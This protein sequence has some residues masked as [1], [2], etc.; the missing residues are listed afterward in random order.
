MNTPNEHEPQNEHEHEHEQEQNHEPE[1]E[2]ENDS[3][4]MESDPPESQESGEA[5]EAMQSEEL[6]STSPQPLAHAKGPLQEYMDEN[7]LQYA[8][9][10]IRDRAIP[11]LDD[12]L[13][14]V[15]R[16]ILHSLNRNDD[17]KFIKVANIV[18]YAMQFHPHGDASIN[19]AL[20]GL[21]NKQYLIEGQGNYGNILTGHRAAASRYI[22][23]R[24]TELSRTQVFNDEITEFVP[25]YDGRG[26]EPVVLPCKIPLLLMQGAEGIAVGLSARI[27]P[28]NFQEL[29]E[30]QIAILKNKPFEVLPDFIQGGY[31]DAADYNDGNGKIKVRAKISAKD[32][33]TAVITE[34]PFGSTTESVINSIEDAAKKGKIKIKSIEDYTSEN[35]EI[36][37]ILN[38]GVDVDQA[39]QA[40]YAFTECESSVSC[41]MIVIKDNRPVE[42]SVSSALRHQT[43]MLLEILEKELQ[44]QKVKALEELH[45][46][47][48]VQ[49]FIERKIYSRL[50]TSKSLD[51]MRSTTLEGLSPYKS[52]FVREV[53]DKDLDHL[54]GI[55]IRRISAFDIEKHRDDM[56]ELRAE[57]AGVERRLENVPKYAIEHLRGLL[58]QF[59]HEFKRRTQIATFSAVKVQKIATKALSVSYDS[60]KGYIG[61]QVKGD[62]F[63][64][65]CSEYD[66]LIVFTDDGQYRVIPA[67]EK[68]FIGTNVLH[69][70][71]WDRSRLFTV[72]YREKAV[73]FVK[74][75][76]TG[77]VIQ[78]KEYN[79]IP[80]AAKVLMFSADSPEDIFV[81]Y[82]PAHGQKIN[83]QMFKIKNLAVRTPKSKGVQMTIK[84]IARIACNRPKGWDLTKIPTKNLSSE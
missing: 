34:V 24:L 46:K 14:P 51:D 62:Q 22:E 21:A 53:N 70:E 68:L 29:L 1:L 42:M 49:I 79:C 52:Q 72:I 73:S 37:V 41:R 67:P 13:K 44:L 2:L 7:F 27:L 81:K 82:K 45:L 54:L 11:K 58:K 12:G 69:C 19:D 77:G 36:E 15:Q 3:N 25:S 20:I 65:K 74:R 6:T 47:T 64:I 84:K 17:G 32:K 30:A 71:I 56:D 40:L 55:P 28:H 8:S 5:G 10:V 33:S 83:E 76:K 38:A 9:Y 78:N 50:E 31:M 61:F 43:K 35:V 23:C 16:R 75:F 63:Q 80:S 18:G 59:G 39:I 4:S 66:R 48:L 60:E 26:K 57:L